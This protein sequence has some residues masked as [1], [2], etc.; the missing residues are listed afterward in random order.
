[1]GTRTEKGL[2]GAGKETHL[3][4]AFPATQPDAA[5]KVMAGGNAPLPI[6][7]PVSS[8]P[9]PQAGV[10]KCASH[11][12]GQC[13]SNG[14]LRQK[15]KRGRFPLSSPRNCSLATIAVLA[16]FRCLRPTC[17]GRAEGLSRRGG[18]A[19][20]LLH[21]SPPQCLKQLSGPIGTRFRFHKKRGSKRPSGPGAI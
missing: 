11:A 3:S 17:W 19:G 15:G 1:M 4:S 5:E 10:P 8:T 13:P 2:A 14:G 20:C 16:A 12:P 6:A 21:S 9:P 18:E 7:S